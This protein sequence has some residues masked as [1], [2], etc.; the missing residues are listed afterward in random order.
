MW[1]L[2]LP[3]QIGLRRTLVVEANSDNRVRVAGF[4]SL[5]PYRL[6]TLNEGVTLNE[7]MEVVDFAEPGTVGE[8]YAFYLHP[9]YM[10]VGPGRRNDVCVAARS[11]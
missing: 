8:I 4:S 10:G 2:L 1:A 9:D 7:A 11:D 3:A 6:V 5:G